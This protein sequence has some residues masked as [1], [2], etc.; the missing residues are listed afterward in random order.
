MNIGEILVWESTNA[1][2]LIP[3]VIGLV[4]LVRW[5]RGRAVFT[6]GVGSFCSAI[7]V[8][9]FSRSTCGLDL[10]CYGLRSC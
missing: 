7:R 4:M 6:E 2:L 8:R 3:V 1:L 5:V 9:K 10:R